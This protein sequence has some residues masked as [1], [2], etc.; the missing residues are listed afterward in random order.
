MDGVAPD[1][2]PVEVYR[3]LPAEP[4]LGRLRSVLPAGCSVLDLGAGVGR[5]ANP[6]AAAGHQVV[7]VDDSAEMLSWVDGPECIQADIWS[8]DLGRRFDA[9][10]ALS[11]LVNS[12]APQRCVELLGVCRRHLRDGGVLIVQ[13]Y[14]PAWRPTDGSSTNGAVEIRLHD[15]VG[16]AGRFSAAVTYSVGSRSWSQ[17]FEAAI[18]DDSELASLAVATGLIVTG[19]PDDERAWVLLTTPTQRTTG[20]QVAGSAAGASVNQS[21]LV[22]MGSPRGCR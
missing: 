7:A 11:H 2:S 6:L 1:G 9:V 8:L 21:H 13:R 22:C 17:P 14:P 15:V 3:A 12:S 19:Y 16:D 18:V 4:D 10:L 5:L 20:Q